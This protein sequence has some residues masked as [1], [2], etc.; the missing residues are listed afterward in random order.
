MAGELRINVG[1]GQT[2]TPGWLNLDN[3]PTVRMARIPWFPTPPSRRVFV[4]SVK[5]NNIHWADATRLPVA[6]GAAE[7][8]Y[9][10]HMMEHLDRA[11]AAKFL[12][13]AHRA[14]RPGG[15]IR[16]ALP[17]LRLRAEAYLADDDADAFVESTLMGTD[18]PHDVGAWIKHALVGSRHHLWM[19]DG[20]SLCRLLEASGFVSAVV[21][22]AGETGIPDPG[23][24]DLREREDE[25]V[26]VEAVR[27]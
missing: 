9:S 5:R 17:D 25:S 15:L 22:P 13:E 6:D 7:V 18:R 8:I 26:Y 14:L 24:L 21:R 23:G 20:R 3:S 11:E 27:P 1:C 2:P 16:L 12:S 10:S 4:E 19:Y